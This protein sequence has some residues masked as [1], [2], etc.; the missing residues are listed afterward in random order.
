MTVV[1]VGLCL[2]MVLMVTDGDGGGVDEG[3]YLCMVM[4]VMLMLKW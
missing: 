3:G 2:L 1:M 4:L